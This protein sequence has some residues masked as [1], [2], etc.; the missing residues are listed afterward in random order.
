[1]VQRGAKVQRF[2]G[3]CAT[4]LILRRVNSQAAAPASQAPRSPLRWDRAPVS[5]PGGRCRRERRRTSPRF[6]AGRHSPV[7]FRAAIP[8]GDLRYQLAQLVPAAI[9]SLD[10][11]TVRCQIKRQPIAF[12]E[13][14]RS[15][16]RAGNPDSQ[17]VAPLGNPSIVQHT[18]LHGIYIGLGPR[19]PQL[20]GATCQTM[21]RV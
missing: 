7:C 2:R 14:A 10:D 1:M 9:R 8:C 18:Y 19:S 17:A 6:P 12:G 20:P 16:N 4:R 3:S 21:I 15:R 13:A 5:R 11:T